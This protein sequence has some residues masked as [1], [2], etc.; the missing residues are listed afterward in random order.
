MSGEDAPRP[1][2]ENRI[3]PEIKT[4]KQMQDCFV[5]DQR[6]ANKNDNVAA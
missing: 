1:Y 6:N 5:P 4:N 3:V 2:L